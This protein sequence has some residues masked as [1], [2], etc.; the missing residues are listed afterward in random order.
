MTSDSPA[1]WQIGAIS[2]PLK[3]CQGDPPRGSRCYGDTEPVA[4]GE[5]QSPNPLVRTSPGQWAL[6]LWEA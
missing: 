1:P 6:F 4:K 2:T 5:P 3:S